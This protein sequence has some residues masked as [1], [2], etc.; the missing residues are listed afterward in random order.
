MSQATNVD[1]LR[2]LFETW[3]AGTETWH[4]AQEAWRRGETDMSLFD[5]DVS[6]D[7]TVLPDHVGE[8]YHGHEGV[9]RA[10]ERWIEPFEWLRI[11]VEQ[12][13]EAGDRLVSTHRWRAKARHTGIEL[14]SPLGYVWTF[15][16]GRIIHFRSYID[17]QDALN[18]AG[19]GQ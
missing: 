3:S 17:P 8:T 2:T 4:E 12:I 15:R 13:V 1:T 9:L 5:P 16:D 10:A 6:Y 18:A 19:L 11:D 7:D 14:D